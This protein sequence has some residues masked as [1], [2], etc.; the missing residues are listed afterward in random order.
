MKFPGGSAVQNPPNNVR[1]MGSILGS[2]RPPPPEKEMVTQ[3]SILTWKIPWMEE[4]G[5]LQ[6]MGWQRVRQNSATKQQTTTTTTNLHL[7]S[8]PPVSRNHGPL[9]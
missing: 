9:V 1:D 7:Q 2:G 3:S 6:S 4:P 8:C 5:G